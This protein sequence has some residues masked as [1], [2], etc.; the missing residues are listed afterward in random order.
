MKNEA[1]TRWG[2]RKIG[3]EE[4]ARREAD[5]VMGE[6]GASTRYGSRK[7]GGHDS[8]P[9]TPEAP[10]GPGPEPSTA[11]SPEAPNNPEATTAPGRPANENR[12][13]RAADADGDGRVTLDELET[14]LAAE[15]G[16]FDDAVKAEFSKG[17]TGVR[18]G[19]AKLFAKTENERAEPRESVLKLLK[20]HL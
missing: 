9:Q 16:L 3:E 8:N 6:E 20:P 10:Q 19:A 5:R 13:L 11:P 1:T 12:F 4:F 18:K 7:G 2:P 14:I 17:A 15:P